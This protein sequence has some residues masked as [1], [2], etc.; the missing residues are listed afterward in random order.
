VELR[1]LRYVIAVAE[2]LHF[3]Q[4]AGRLH[5]AA[6]SLSKQIRQLEMLLGYPLFERRT[7]QV[8]LTTAGSAF[9][10]EAREAL[11]HVVLAL[12]LSAAAN[13]A[14]TGS[15][16]I[17][18]S[19]WIDVPWII[20]AKNRFD[21]EIGIEALLRSEHTAAQ[22]ESVLTGKLSAGIMVLPIRVPDLEVRVLRQERLVLALPRSHPSA[23]ES[24][25]D[26]KAL[27]NQPI[28]SIRDSVE[29]ALSDYLRCVGKENGFEPR[30][31][32]E[33]TTTS[34]A[35]ELV[36][37]NVGAALVRGS[38]SA[39]LQHQGVVFRHCTELELRVEIGLVYSAHQAPPAVE[40]LF[41]FLR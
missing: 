5:L 36:A 21:R 33:V 7:R 25:L 31:V 12:D 38:L 20:A 18:Y 11:N 1:H 23:A 34:E 13:R 29:P 3:A 9:V 2:D 37:S 39:R 17:G 10:S 14:A 15:L 8:R 30:I 19:P 4:A 41:A 24:S 32:Q 22:T 28:I 27:A 35:L 16:A 6:P 40:L 26:V